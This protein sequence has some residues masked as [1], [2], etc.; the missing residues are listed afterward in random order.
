VNLL[1]LLGR[2]AAWMDDALCAQVGG[3]FWHPRKGK[4]GKSDEVQAKRTCGLCPVKQA[5][6]QHARVHAEP[7]GIWGGV[8]PRPRRAMRAELGLGPVNKDLDDWHGTEAG[9][10]RH[11]RMGEKSCQRCRD[12]ANLASR[13]RIR[14]RAE[15]AS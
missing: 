6:L 9:D 14:L 13:E 5:C 4:G 8:S 7:D 1:E 3:D 10:K 15:V 11:T 2:Q 12:A